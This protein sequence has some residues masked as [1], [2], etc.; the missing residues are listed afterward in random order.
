M[1][2]VSIVIA[3]VLAAMVTPPANAAAAWFVEGEELTTTAALA[4]TAAVDEKTVLAAAAAGVSVECNGAALNAVNPEI[5]A[6]N[7]LTAADL[8]FTGCTS[9]VSTCSLE[10]S[11]IKTEPVVAELTEQSPPAAVAVF[12]P[13]T[14]TLITSIAFLGSECS[15]AGE[16]PVTGRVRALLPTGEEEYV[17]QDVGWL[18]KESSGELKIGS[19]GASLTGS[20][21]LT[22]ANANSWAFFGPNEPDITLTRSAGNG[23]LKTL[24][25][26]KLKG[27]TCEIEVKV[28]KLGKGTE[29]KFIGD[30]FFKRN[31]EEIEFKMIPAAKKECKKG[32]VIGVLKATCFVKIE[33]FG[34][35]NPGKAK[36]QAAYTA[37]A[38]EKGGVGKTTLDVELLEAEEI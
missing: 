6:P 15:L 11:K 24:C 7:T 28:I 38:E 26:F 33:Y 35:S 21:L 29:L 2:R 27:D 37:I 13:K 31:E 34:N 10:T 4:S 16:E 18:P 20:A 5:A 9:G 12:K 36:Y 1:L 30:M 8:E 32:E 25:G 17:S 22:L 19:A 14:G 3:A 23:K